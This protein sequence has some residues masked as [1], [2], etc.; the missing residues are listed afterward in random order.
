MCSVDRTRPASLTAAPSQSR[1]RTSR[2]SPASA[3][4]PFGP[5]SP[6]ARGTP[7]DRASRTRALACPSLV[8][9]FRSVSQ[10]PHH[11]RFDARST[12]H[13]KHGTPGETRATGVG[14]V[15]ASRVAAAGLQA[16]GVHRAGRGGPRCALLCSKGGWIDER[17]LPLRRLARRPRAPSGAVELVGR[18]ARLYSTKPVTAKW[19]EQGRR[20][21]HALRF[22]TARALGVA[23]STLHRWID[24]GF[25][26]VEEQAPGA[27]WPVG[28]DGALGSRLC[29]PTRQNPQGT[30]RDRQGGAKPGHTHAVSQVRHRTARVGRSTE[31]FVYQRVRENSAR[32][33]DQSYSAGA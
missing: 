17:E 27:M 2:Q 25:V 20:T 31:L 8:A 21:M 30:A 4:R 15:R 11:L 5:A 26:S 16:V 22:K 10:E 9:T 7:S 24:M 23:S 33:G 13:E 19:T 12:V 3:D 6:P 1:S 18:L 29:I 32:L 28:V 14:V